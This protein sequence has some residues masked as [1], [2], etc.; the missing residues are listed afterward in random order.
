MTIL[1]I[2]HVLTAFIALGI[3]IAIFVRRKGDRPHKLLGWIYVALM[4]PGLIAIIIAGGATPRPFHLYA[5][6]IVVCVLAA[7][8]ASRFRHRLPGWRAWHA[9]LMSFSM[10]GACA[11]TGGVVGGVVMGLGN[12]PD[13]YRMFN[14]AI[15]IISALG[16]WLL[17]KHPVI[18]GPKPGEREQN[19]RVR[20]G[21]GIM[22]VSAGLIGSQWALLM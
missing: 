19:I 13:Y 9:A 18:W 3:G 11:A 14:I 12:G 22:A 1:S 6:V 17:L 16:L 21:V 15:A 2:T 8:A 10:I 7:I 20:V 5:L 4:V